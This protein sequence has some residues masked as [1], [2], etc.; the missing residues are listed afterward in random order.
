MVST[1]KILLQ[2]GQNSQIREPKHPNCFPHVEFLTT[3]HCIN[4]VFAIYAVPYY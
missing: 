2:E 1:P 3:L 4:A